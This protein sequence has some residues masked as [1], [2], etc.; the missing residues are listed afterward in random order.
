MYAKCGKQG[1]AHSVLVTLSTRNVVT[2]NALLAGCAQHGHSKDV[3]QFFHAMQQEGIKPDC[4]T[5]LVVLKAFPD[6]SSLQDG[7][8]IHA[9]MVENGLHLDS[10]VGSSLIDMY[11]KCCSL[12]DACK[13]YNDLPWQNVVTW[14]VM[15]A[16]YTQNGHSDKALQLFQQVK[17]GGLQ[18]DNVTYTFVLKSC[19]TMKALD[20]G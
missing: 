16:G 7:R 2:W 9:S 8:L 4:A 12:K 3:I 6:I 10:F 11:C 15:I 5:F 13:V 19:S 20:Q 1:E 18:L 14:N 17:Q